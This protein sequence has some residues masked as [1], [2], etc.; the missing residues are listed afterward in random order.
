MHLAGTMRINSSGHLEIGG[1]DTT[2]L[3]KKFGTPLWIID[4]EGFRQ[5]CRSFSNAFHSLGDSL[6]AYASKSLCSL[7]IC[8]IVKEE[9]LGLDIVSGG[10]LYTAI[11]AGF[12]A[13]KIYFH[14]NN[15]SIEEL[16]MAVRYGVGCIVVDNFY[17]LELLNKICG[18]EGL[19]Q[20]IMLR[21]TPGV[22]AHTHEYIQTGQIDSKF[23]FTLPD[24]Q[25][26]QAVLT[27]VTTT[28]LNL[29]GLHCH[30]G[31]QI[32][33]MESFRYSTALMMNFMVE[34]K[35]QIGYE[36]KVL[37]I[38][39]GFGIFYKT[40]DEPCDPREWAESVMLTVREK[41]DE[42]GLK[43]PRVIIEPGRAI[44]GPAGI[45]LYTIGSWKKILGLRKYVSV[46]GGMADNPRPALYGAEY[47]C[48]LANKAD[49]PGIE[50]VTIAG[51]CCESGDMLIRDAKLPPAEPGDILAVFA[52]GAYTYAMSGNYNRLPRPAM[53][54]VKQGKADVIVRR[55]TYEDLLRNDLIPE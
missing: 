19:T 36:M 20:D 18:Q 55:E 8:R 51:K 46:D 14:G 37:D 43:V 38:G 52:T 2:D 45:T 30:I 28:N 35:E 3:V 24:G 21:I 22:E 29:I 12:P 15:K 4:E 47:T 53:V 39:G 41:A 26:M 49:Q 1:I 7:A 27:A 9:G 17:E 31:S 34:I 42:S 40:G 6:V 16:T 23:G 32:F 25:A 54:L 50:K 48:L 5:N 33:E 44:S 10:E 11:K 13:Q